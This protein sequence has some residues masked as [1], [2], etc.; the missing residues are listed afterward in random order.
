MARGPS[1]TGARGSPPVAA[2]QEVHH[3]SG[4]QQRQHSNGCWP[5]KCLHLLRQTLSKQLP[6]PRGRP[7]GTGSFSWSITRPHRPA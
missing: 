1:S 3:R 6:L 7:A 2:V 4:S 5:V